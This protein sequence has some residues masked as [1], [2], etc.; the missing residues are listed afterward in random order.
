MIQMSRK[1]NKHRRSAPSVPPA[2]LMPELAELVAIIEQTQ[3]RVLS[4]EERAKLKTIAT[5]TTFLIAELQKKQTSLDRL[6]RM[7]FGAPTEKTRLVLETHTSKHAADAGAVAPEHEAD[8]RPK[9][10]GH[11]RH[12]AA[13]YTGA[14]K[15]SV[16]HPTLQGGQACPGCEKGRVYGELSCECGLRHGAASAKVYECDRLRCNLCGEVYRAAP[17][18]GRWKYDATAISMVGPLVR[19]GA[20]VQPH[21]TLQEGMRTAPA[22]TS[23]I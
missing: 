19:H 17:K 6:R 15:V 8:P 12:S 4:D 9:P 23:G 14:D 13:A 20:A 22:A 5:T 2:Q 11:G 21:Q 10:P 16:H 7:L 1:K 3:S 18:A